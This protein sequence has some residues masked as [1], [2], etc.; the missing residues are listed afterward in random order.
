VGEWEE[1]VETGVE[2]SVLKEV[3]RTSVAVEDGF[4]SLSLSS[5]AMDTDD[6]W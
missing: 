5:D 1:R 4:V 6:G 2:E 3:G